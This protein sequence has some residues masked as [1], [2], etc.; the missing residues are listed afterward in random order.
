[1]DERR[2]AF[3]FDFISPY[4]WMAAERIG[5]MCRDADRDLDWNPFLLKAT[6]VD[7]MG[8]KPLLETPLKGDYLKHDCRRM[9]RLYGLTMADDPVF[10]F[11][12]LGAARLTTWAKQRHPDQVEALVL[13]LYRRH[14]SEGGDISRADELVAVADRVGLDGCAGGRGDR[15]SRFQGPFPPVGRRYHRARRVRLS[16]H[17]RRRRDVLGRGPPGAGSAV[18][19]GR[20]LVGSESG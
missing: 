5:A 14:W 1:M 9:T 13:A 18:D 2:V 19:A 7:T 11:S 3:Y 8:Q 17:H 20:R 6:V 4:G 16:H 10:T 15:R 12:S